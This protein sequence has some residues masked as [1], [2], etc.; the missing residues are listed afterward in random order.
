MSF[1]DMALTEDSA[2]AIGNS[3]LLTFTFPEVI[4]V[5]KAKN[6]DSSFEF[7]K[8]IES[9]T[10]A[11]GQKATVTIPVHAIPCIDG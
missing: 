8:P 9:E 5:T 10:S 1:L 11:D 2:V 3:V 7:S 4:H 6:N